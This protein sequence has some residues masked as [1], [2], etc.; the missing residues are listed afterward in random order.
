[1]TKSGAFKICK[2]L[3]MCGLICLFSMSSLQQAYASDASEGEGFNPGDMINH[4]IKDAHGWEITH[5]VVVPLPIILYSE[6]DGLMI[7]SSSNFFCVIWRT[8]LKK[9]RCNFDKIL[10]RICKKPCLILGTHPQKSI[11]G[12]GLASAS[13]IIYN[14]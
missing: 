10:A 14:I 11:R 12:G 1:M 3:I 6:P 4:H 7:F 2:E 13:S 9:I 5:G 8:I